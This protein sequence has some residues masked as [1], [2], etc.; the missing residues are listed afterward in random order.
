MLNQGMVEEEE[1][2]IN[3]KCVPLGAEEYETFEITEGGHHKVIHGTR[4]KECLAKRV[5]NVSISQQRDVG[6]HHWNAWWMP[7]SGSHA[8]RRH[9]AKG[10]VPSRPHRMTHGG[11]R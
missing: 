4:P 2:V 6:G 1:T 10:L 3:K 5:R 9:F 7:Q 8:I 11:H